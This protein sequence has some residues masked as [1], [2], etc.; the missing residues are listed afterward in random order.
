M[1][2]L[3]EHFSNCGVE[4]MSIQ[5]IDCVKGEDE[6]LSILEGYWQNPSATFKTNDKNVNIQMNGE[7]IWINSP[8]VLKSYVI[9]NKFRRSL[10]S[11]MI[12]YYV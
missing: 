5:I 3:G 10:F 1:S 9:Y 6:A 12:I 2:E 8:Y 7:T 11:S 4:N